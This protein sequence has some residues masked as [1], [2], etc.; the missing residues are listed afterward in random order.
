MSLESV[1]NIAD[2][3][4]TNPTPSD[5]KADGDDHLR[6]IKKAM[7]NGFAGFTGSVMVTG[8]DGGAAN[9]YTLTPANALPAYGNKMVAV[10][11]PTAANT[12]ASS[13]NISG[14]GVK[15]LTSVSG[16]ALVAGDLAVGSIYAAYYDGT[17]FRLLAVT[18]NYVDQAVVAG[19]IPAQSLGF[20]R[21]DGTVSAFTQ[22]HTGY[23]QKEV[24]GA[25]IASAA[26]IDLTAAT[27]NLVHITGN[28]AITSITVAVGAEYTII[29]D[30]TPTLTHS[31]A[32]LLPTGASV[33]AQAGDRI[34]V[35]GDTAGANVV[36]WTRA[37]GTALAATT[38]ALT[39]LATMTPTAAASLD[40][41]SV[42][43][44]TYD[45]YL[46]VCDGLLPATGSSTLQL[47]AAN[48]GTVD[49]SSSYYNLDV[50]GPSSGSSAN[51]LNVGGTT[52]S[53]GRG[54]NVEI[55]LRNVNSATKAKTINSLFAMQDSATPTFQAS[56]SAG[57]YT[58]TAIS[59]FRLSWFSGALFAAD[60]K[61]RVYG[62]Q[63][64]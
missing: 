7:L 11:A 17:R 3:V 38:F 28:V 47:R 56:Q 52:L 63:N 57:F 40:L 14:L 49:A 27:G 54:A 39:L 16:A 58:G 8:T 2:L 9:A 32:L 48:S 31:A 6:N 34:K 25:D 1:T 64:A 53:S 62:Y 18:K 20:Y 22:T 5:P 37:N 59:G 45:N 23:A 36:S 26:N 15:S 19:T 4:N 51:A 10:F 43:N 30:G 41:L 50:A 24:K 55:R 12:G 33:T 61:V 60:G 44:S 13:L 21:S 46:I 35:R 42:F 29:F